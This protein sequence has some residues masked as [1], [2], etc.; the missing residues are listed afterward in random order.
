MS[1]QQQEPVID[2]KAVIAKFND[3]NK[4]SKALL[5][6]VTELEVD[7][8]EHQLVEDTLK[9]LDPKRRAFRL[10]GGVLVEQTVEEV[11][12]NITDNL[13]NMRQVIDT[14][15]E[16]LKTKNTDLIN[17]KNKYNIKTAEEAE[18]LRKQQMVN[19]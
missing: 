2:E 5:Q 7:F 1:E 10:I 14:L 9:P 3:L 12:P 18:A 11:I 6:K 16:Q 8:N 13:K 15:K 17:W 19:A 4:E